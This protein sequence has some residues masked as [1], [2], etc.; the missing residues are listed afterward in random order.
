MN[1]FLDGSMQKD[2]RGT[3]RTLS[4]VFFFVPFVLYVLIGWGELLDRPQA[5]DVGVVAVAAALGG[6]VLNAGLRL[7]GCKRKKPFKRR[8]SSSQ[9]LY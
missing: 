9:S 2:D 7:H 5:L 6:L 3:A 8:K 4:L 1:A